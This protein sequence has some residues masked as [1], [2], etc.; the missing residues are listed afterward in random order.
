MTLFDIHTHNN[1]ADDEYSIYNC[2]E[3]IEGRKISI[4]I[5]PWEI[6]DGW[7]ERF[8]AIKLFQNLILQVNQ[9]LTTLPCQIHQF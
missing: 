9:L 5:H 2:K 1:R 8:A 7:K 4:G 6:N 3:Y